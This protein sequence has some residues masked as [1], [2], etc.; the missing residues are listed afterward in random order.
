MLITTTPFLEGYVIEKYHGIVTSHV[1]EGANAFKDFAG[2]VRDIVGGRSATYEKV[3]RKADHEAVKELW[4]Q[5]EAG[6]ANAVIGIDLDYETISFTGQMLM[7][8]GTGTAVTVRKLGEDEQ[9]REG[10]TDRGAAISGPSTAGATPRLSAIPPAPTG[11]QD[12]MTPV[13]SDRYGHRPIGEGFDHD[14]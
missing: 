1:V 8:I 10:R 14:R 5:A 13:Q 9:H 4:K 2:K 6:G 7:I 12:P 11:T 3:L